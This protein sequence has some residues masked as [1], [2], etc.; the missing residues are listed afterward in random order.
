MSA[1]E[2][3]IS[4]NFQLSVA[5]WYYDLEI[6]TSNLAEGKQF[7]LKRTLETLEAFLCLEV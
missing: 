2:A 7:N 6:Q 5:H 3:D 4:I 1:R